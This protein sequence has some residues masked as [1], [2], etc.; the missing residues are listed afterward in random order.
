MVFPIIHFLL[1][2]I[3]VY[4]SVQLSLCV[5]G[6]GRLSVICVSVQINAEKRSGQISTT[7][8]RP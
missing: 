7:N 6:A 5:F 3:E 4:R 2:A 8:S 1:P